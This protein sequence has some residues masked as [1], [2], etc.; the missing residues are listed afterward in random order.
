MFSER[1]M[2]AKSSQALQNIPGVHEVRLGMINGV[3]LF[4]IEGYASPLD[5]PLRRCLISTS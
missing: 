2:R 4:G 3:Q 1:R 5:G